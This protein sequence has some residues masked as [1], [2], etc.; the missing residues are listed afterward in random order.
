[1]N[2]FST[3]AGRPGLVLGIAGAIGAV[4]VAGAVLRPAI[5]AL[6]AG[7]ALPPRAQAVNLPPELKR[8]L[9]P[10][11]ETEEALVALADELS[12]SVVSIS[13]ILQNG[14]PLAGGPMGSGSGFVITREG[15]IVTND[16]VVNG[17]ERVNVTFTDGRQV[18]GRVFG[19]N[20]ATIDLALVK[21]DP[22][23]LELL[24]L[25]LGDSS[26][27]RPGQ[28]AIAIGSPFNLENTVTIGHISAVNRSNVV[29]DQTQIRNYVGM[30]QTDASINPGNSGGPLLNIDGEVIGVNSSIVSGTNSSAGLG[31]ALPA[32]T[33]AVVA[34]EIMKTR[35]FDRGVIG[36]VPQNIPPYELKEMK[37]EGGVR[38]AEVQEGSP[39]ALAGI[40]AE[41][42]LLEV[43][44]RPL[45]SEADLFQAMFASSPGQ[46]AEVK[47]R[48]KDGSIRVLDLKLG[49]PQVQAQAVPNQELRRR[50]PEFFERE[51][52]RGL[53]PQ[54]V[55]RPRLGASIEPVSEENRRQ[56]SIP[57]G[58]EGAV[59]IAVTPESPGAKAG[60]QVGDVIVKMGSAA[61]GN[62]QD[63]LSQIEGLEPGASMTV[64]VRRKSE[65][66][67]LKVSF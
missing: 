67:V 42:I 26:Q 37:L 60:L 54:I 64:E 57:E 43:N 13:P 39:A 17:A 4:A 65:T 53:P 63:V 10:V 9:G 50:V 49:K 34:E 31:F 52:D 33:V 15:W 23:G 11:R 3:L 62:V 47:V 30:I 38:A 55:P 21:V 44:S 29:G 12:P 36:V 5:P 45:R 41:D 7:E 56:F 27:V 51:F 14:M 6:R 48:A 1:M 2:P 58:I 66:A 61:I 40:Q 16:H 59:V 28:F 20:D 8:S 22:K 35:K 46:M 24:P 32:S 18:E 25:P 19:T